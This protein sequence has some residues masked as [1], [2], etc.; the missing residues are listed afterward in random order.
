MEKDIYAIIAIIISLLI[1]FNFKRKT[2]SII[3]NLSYV[4]VLI[5][6]IIFILSMIRTGFNLNGFLVSFKEAFQ[7]MV[8]VTSVSMVFTSF[9]SFMYNKSINLIVYLEQEDFYSNNTEIYLKI[10]NKTILHVE[11]LKIKILNE[12]KLNH[13]CEFLDNEIGSICANSE[14]SFHIGTKRYPF[15]SIFNTTYCYKT[16]N[17]TKPLLNFDKLELEITGS[18]KNILGEK[19]LFKDTKTLMIYQ[20]KSTDGLMNEQQLSNKEQIESLIKY[21][22]HINNKK[23]P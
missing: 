1:C 18:Y 14:R 5:G 20:L 22:N 6:G 23:N 17:P 8:F 12:K 2:K 19:K 16:L 9:C 3:K 4:W 15:I 11:D 13:N 21:Y 7:I 10:E